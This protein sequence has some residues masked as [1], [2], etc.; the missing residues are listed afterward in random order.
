MKKPLSIYLT[1]CLLTLTLLLAACAS[2][3]TT[4]TTNQTTN[5]QPTA[6]TTSSTPSPTQ[7]SNASFV[8]YTGKGYTINYRPSWKVE[9]DGNNGVTF[10]DPAQKGSVLHVIVQTQSPTAALQIEEGTSLKD[11]CKESGNLLATAD[12]NGVTW[13][14]GE[15]RCSSAIANG[16]DQEIRTLDMAKPVGNT[17]YS[18]A[19]YSTPQNFDN[20][21]IGTFR[22]MTDSF[23]VK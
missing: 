14:Q 7:S 1:G 16:S 20:A 6:T 13:N 19:F 22:P 21:V 4:T 15:Y 9:S 23:K 8:T 18:I 5:N 12:I 2:N 11:R 10:T 17:Y 3:Q